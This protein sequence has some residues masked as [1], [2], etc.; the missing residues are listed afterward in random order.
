[1]K[2]LQL[3]I[4]AL[5]TSALVACGGTP[6]KPSN[7]SSAAQSAVDSDKVTV[8]SVPQV[9]QIDKT[10]GPFSQAAL[11]ECTLT[12]QYTQLLQEHASE[13]GINVTVVDTQEPTQQGYFLLP[14]FTRIDSKGNPFIGHHKYTEMRLTLYKDG[15]KVSTADFGRLSGGGLF[16]GYKGSCSVLGRTVEANAED[17]VM[18]LHSPVQGARF[19]D[20]N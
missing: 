3:T 10:K 4:L 5:S 17:T 2:K 1:M 16:A 9:A 18:W 7:D 12:T 11:S 8:V 15:K 14:T 20:L 6:T 19:G 13:S